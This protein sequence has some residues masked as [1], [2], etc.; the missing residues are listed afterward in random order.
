V[1]SRA[2]RLSARPHTGDARSHEQRRLTCGSICRW[3]WWSLV[4]TATKGSS[5]RISSVPAS[6]R[7]SVPV[8]KRTKRRCRVGGHASTTAHSASASGAALAASSSS[9]TTRN[10]CPGTPPPLHGHARI[11]HHAPREKPGTCVTSNQGR[12]WPSAP[13]AH[14]RRQWRNGD[15]GG[16]MG[17]VAWGRMAWRRELTSRTATGPSAAASS[18]PPTMAARSVAVTAH[19]SSSVGSSASLSPTCISRSCHSTAPR[20]ASSTACC[21]Y[22]SRDVDAGI[23]SSSSIACAGGG[24]REGRHFRTQ[25]GGPQQ[26]HLYPCSVRPAAHSSIRD[27]LGGRL[28]G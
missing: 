6:G 11:I 17:G 26:K 20:N 28:H 5:T 4:L 7:R 10:T 14:E 15:D 24:R 19:S 3:R 13:C 12:R 8:T 27:V 23:P 2:G 25:C 21:T 1:R 18:A 16:G 9:S 22:R